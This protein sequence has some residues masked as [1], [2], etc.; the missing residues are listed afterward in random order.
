LDRWIVSGG[1]ALL[2][3]GH[4]TGLMCTTVYLWC[5]NHLFCIRPG[6]MAETFY[7]CCMYFGWGSLNLPTAVYSY[8]FEYQL[9][10]DLINPNYNSNFRLVSFESVFPSNGL[11]VSNFIVLLNQKKVRKIRIFSTEKTMM[12]GIWTQNFGLAFGSL[13]HCTIESV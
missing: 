3:A 9:I 1:V 7:L 12:T 5:H 6:F 11:W 10:V 2:H 4:K 8:F 13:D